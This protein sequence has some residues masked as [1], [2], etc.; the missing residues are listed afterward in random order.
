MLFWSQRVGIKC[1]ITAPPSNA[2][3][4]PNTAGLLSQNIN[5][6]PSSYCASQCRNYRASVPGLV[7]TGFILQTDEST[8]SYTRHIQAMDQTLS[9]RD[10]ESLCKWQGWR[11]KWPGQNKRA[12]VAHIGD[13]PGSARPSGI[14]DTTWQGTTWPLSH[15]TITLKNIR[16]SWL[17]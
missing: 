5:P 11:M 15:K 16:Y 6:N 2:C 13:T 17:P 4:S 8:P 1:E 3:L 12:H 9:T 14:R 7:A 10:K